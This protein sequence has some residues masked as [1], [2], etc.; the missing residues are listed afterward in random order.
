MGAG[1]PDLLKRLLG[2]TLPRPVSFRACP[3]RRLEALSLFVDGQGVV[4][5]PNPRAQFGIMKFVVP[6]ADP[7]R[8]SERN[9]QCAYGVPNANEEDRS[10]PVAQDGRR[11]PVG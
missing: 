8:P 4:G 7:S 6:F 2:H 10:R 3:Q 1:K 11:E 5:E 9:A